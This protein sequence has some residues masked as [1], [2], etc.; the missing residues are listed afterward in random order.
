MTIFTEDRIRE[1]L[2]EAARRTEFAR[3]IVS[4]DGECNNPP[5]RAH[6]IQ[7]ALLRNI[8]DEEDKVQQF[9]H[10]R[11]ESWDRWSEDRLV[12][13]ST[14]SAA[15]LRFACATHDGIFHEFEMHGVDWKNPRHKTLLAHRALKASEFVSRRM[16]RLLE[17][18]I[19]TL[20][21]Y[22]EHEFFQN[23]RLNLVD[24]LKF[25]EPLS[26]LVQESILRD[27]YDNIRHRV[28]YIDAKQS[29]GAIGVVPH[30]PQ[31]SFIYGEYGNANM[32]VPITSVP[33]AVTLLPDSGRQILLL[34]YNKNSLLDVQN[35]LD[36][37]E[38]DNGSIS[39]GRLS[40]KLLEESELI[41]I[42]PYAW[43]SFDNAVQHLILSYFRA[44]I[45]TNNRELDVHP[46][47]VDLFRLS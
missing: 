24:F 27:R 9:F 39:T 3:C 40:K 4:I 41:V 18:L 22:Q 8:A 11:P 47:A 2:Q 30:P 15:Q 7:R 16:L 1:L 34:S 6:F 21:T 25:Y 26:L 14:R 44:S 12:R 32:V 10:L 42:S 43:N 37:L 46:S 29:V 23:S 19:P 31:E 45:G 33:I 5:I 36:I 38:Y 13:I 17:E 20:D 28:I 35:F